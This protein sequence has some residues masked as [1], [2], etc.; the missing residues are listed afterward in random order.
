L[1]CERAITV[2]C[3]LVSMAKPAPHYVNDDTPMGRV[4]NEHAD[5]LW[6]LEE[7]LME[8]APSMAR[9][10]SAVSSI[11]EDTTEVK[12]ELGTLKRDVEEL[13]Q[14]R[15]EAKSDLQNLRQAEA[16]RVEQKRDIKK[17]V[18]SIVGAAIVA[19]LSFFLGWNGSK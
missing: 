19:A 12:E 16:N 13:K 17:M 8:M 1:L 5:R 3:N 7:I 6:R 11:K 14:Y 10:E 15:Q 18:Y 2:D 4:T 9:L